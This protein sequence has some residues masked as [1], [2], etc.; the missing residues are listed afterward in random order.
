MELTPIK[1]RGRG[2][3]KKAW[4]PP[5]PRRIMEKRKR[6]RTQDGAIPMHDVDGLPRKR[7]K[8]KKPPA[9]IEN[10]PVELLERIILLSRN[11]K[12]LFSSLRIGKRFSHPQ[13]LTELVEA[14]FA[15]TWDELFAHPDTNGMVRNMTV[16]VPGDPEF[17]TDVL[18]CQWV[19]A[20][21]VLDAQQKW[22]RRTNG[23]QWFS[24]LPGDRERAL[25][26]M[27]GVKARYEEEWKRF[28]IGCLDCLKPP[29][30]AREPDVWRAMLR[31]VDKRFDV[32]P[33]IRIP[34]RL[35]TDPCG[36][37]SM[38][39]LF[40]LVRGGARLQPEHSGDWELTEKG[41]DTVMAMA[42]P[43]LGVV[44]LQL[45]YDLRAFCHWPP[46]HLEEK[47]EIAQELEQRETD[48]DKKLMWSA[49]QSVLKS[50]DATAMD[51]LDQIHITSIP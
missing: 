38:R 13:F 16:N 34:R 4:R 15:P 48:G 5:E 42:N 51:G 47:L 21:L 2:R 12:F 44:Y 37:D 30:V 19:N 50:F 27:E 8:S 29:E 25:S 31:M 10:L 39:L 7:C 28:Q 35:L 23:L 41:F 17:Q 40:W 22:A 11:L 45:L 20:D 43:H 1:V 26:L 36:W 3:Q 32:H 18:N 14:A 33:R 6:K 9:P 24:K 46:G 49:G